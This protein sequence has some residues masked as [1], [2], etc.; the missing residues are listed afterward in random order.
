MVRQM[1]HKEAWMRF[2]GLKTCD[3]CR[4]ALKALRDAG[5]DPV[6]IDVRD[7]GV[8]PEDLAQMI[9]EFGES[10]INRRSTTW[11][12]LGETDRARDPAVL[13]AAHPTLLKRP[14]ID[15]GAWTI[16]WTPD[17]QARHLGG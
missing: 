12:D 9:A 15:N 17:V 13:L 16:G 5:F 2:F 6:V 10:A 3:T 11:R 7:D 4:K 8:S 1:L 14:V